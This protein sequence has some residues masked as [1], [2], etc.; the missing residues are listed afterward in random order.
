MATKTKAK[1]LKPG[2][3]YRG[4]LRK[5]IT[6]RKRGAWMLVTYAYRVADERGRESFYRQAIPPVD[7]LHVNKLEEVL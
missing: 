1:N 2:D 7:K 3:V 4:G 6:V 5:A